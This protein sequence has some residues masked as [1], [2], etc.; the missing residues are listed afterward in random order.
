MVATG[1]LNYDLGDNFIAYTK[2]EAVYVYYW[3]DGSTGRLSNSN[4]R[5]L[6]ASVTDDVVLWYD[7][8]DG[9]IGDK[10]KDRDVLMMA[11]IP[12]EK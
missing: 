12:F 4:S 7:I 6:L 11:T 8:T 5:A 9:I 2:D 1:V 10:E 3:A